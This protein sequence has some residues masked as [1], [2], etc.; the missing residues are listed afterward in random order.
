MR[1]DDEGGDLGFQ[2]FDRMR[3]E[4]FAGEQTDVFSFLMYNLG[5]DVK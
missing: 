3:D 4:R 2:S 5:M 1:T